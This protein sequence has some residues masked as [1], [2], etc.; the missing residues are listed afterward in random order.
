M[1]LRAICLREFEQC[2]GENTTRKVDDRVGRVSER[3]SERVSQLD[4][5]VACPE[6]TK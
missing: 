3:V 4:V 5:D 1:R 2:A 6:L